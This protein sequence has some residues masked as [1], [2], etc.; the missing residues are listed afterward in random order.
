MHTFISYA[1]EQSELAREIALAL[2][3]EGHDVFLDRSQLPEGDAYNARIRQAIRD[4]DLLVF[5]VS[6]DAVS[7]GR[8]TLTELKFAEENWPRPAGHLLPVMVKPTEKDRI[9]PFLRSV[10]ILQPDGNVA[11]EVV[12][13]VARL[14]RPWWADAVRRYAAALAVLAAL[15]AGYAGWRLYAHWQ[16]NREALGLLGQCKVQ[17]EAG[18]YAAA[19]ECDAR[20]AVAAPRNDTVAQAQE[21]LA[22]DWLDNIRVTE[23]KQTFTDIANTLQPVL[24]R[25]AASPDDRRAA[26]ALAH[27]GW[28]DFL[29]SREGAIGLDPPH[30]YRQAIQRDPQNVYAH[31]MWG[32]DLLQRGGSLDEAKAHFA[33]AIATGEQRPYVRRIQIAALMW[34]DDPD[35]QNELVRVANEMRTRARHDPPATQTTRRSGACG[36]CTTTA[37]SWA[38]T[39]RAF[40]PPCHRQIIWRPS[41]GCIPRRPSPKTSVPRTSTCWRSCRSRPAIEPPPSP[42]TVRC[43]RPRQHMGSRAAG[44]LTTRGGPS[45][46]SGVNDAADGSSGRTLAIC[47]TLGTHSVGVN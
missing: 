36:T 9:P 13:A 3:G 31:A 41:A 17:E 7:A 42:P 47:R 21:R 10:T 14:A 12:A 24:A 4:C 23:G 33:N 40:S 18:D 16:A 20:A 15:G 30:Y 44:C 29:R 27:L 2:R 46:V 39:R 6:P 8:Y 5:L 1:S 37:S 22:M 43:S 32:H 25:G 28:A 26:N 45:R 38:P 19:W 34:R 11:A 35:L